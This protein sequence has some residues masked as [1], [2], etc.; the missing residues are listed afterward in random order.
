MRVFMHVHMHV[1]VPSQSDA[2]K[3]RNRLQ[4][5]SLWMLRSALMAP[6]GSSVRHVLLNESESARTHH[7]AHRTNSVVFLNHE[8]LDVF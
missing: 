8:A 1:L 7:A 6:S 2:C 5:G 4:G 3:R